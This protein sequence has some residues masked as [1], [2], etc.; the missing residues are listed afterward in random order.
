MRH[1]DAGCPL[2]TLFKI[3]FEWV[4]GWVFEWVDEKELKFF[5]SAMAPYYVVNVGLASSFIM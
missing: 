5:E 4:L 2:I 1:P 3:A